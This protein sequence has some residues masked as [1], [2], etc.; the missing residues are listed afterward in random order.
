MLDARNFEMAAQA[1]LYQEYANTGKTGKEVT[2]DD[3]A[4]DGISKYINDVIGEDGKK[5]VSSAT[6]TTDEKGTITKLVYNSADKYTATYELTG[7]NAGWK[8]EPTE[9]GCSDT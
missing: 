2:Y 5:K 9:A 7:D 8:I 6:I 3:K 4:K 1:G